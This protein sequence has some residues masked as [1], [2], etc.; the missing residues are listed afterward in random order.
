MRV[1]IPATHKPYFTGGETVYLDSTDDSAYW[2]F[3]SEIWAQQESVIVVEHDVVPSTIALKSLWSCPH[4]WCT[5]PYNYLRATDYRGLG[6]VKFSGRLM[7]LVPDL[8]QRVAEMT[9]QA[10][11]GKHWCRLTIRSTEVL[12]ELR[13]ARHDHHLQVA[14]PVHARNAHGCQ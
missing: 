11:P 10:H 5:Q 2:A 13:I 7:A 9:D 6:C 1:F 3:W 4:G 8:W 12:N 14:H